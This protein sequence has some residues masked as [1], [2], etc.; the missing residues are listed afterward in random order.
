[1]LPGAALALDVGTQTIGLAVSDPGRKLAFPV[2]TLARKGVAKDVEA[3]AALCR[4]RDVR[5]LVVG[6]PVDLAGQ[7][8][9]ITRLA[10]QVGEALAARAGLPVAWVDERYT[11]A[12]ARG[13]LDA[14]GVPRGLQKRVVDQEAAVVILEDWLAREGS[15]GRME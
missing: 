3:L 12:E 13:R 6:L 11:T 9:R 5:Q 15:T 10:R 14:A 7:E 4:E 8:T 2:R 1:M